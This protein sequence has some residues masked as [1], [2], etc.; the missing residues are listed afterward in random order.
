MRNFLLPVKRPHTNTNTITTAAVL[1][2]GAV[3]TRAGDA[4]AFAE[5]ICYAP[6]GGPLVSCAPLPEV[7]RPAGKATVA[8]KIAIRSLRST[9]SAARTASHRSRASRPARRTERAPR[10]VGQPAPVGPDHRVRTLTP[11][12]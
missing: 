10:G 3:L 5:D 2:A 11:A 1:L 6:G 8:C 7:C 4:H 12:K 9:R